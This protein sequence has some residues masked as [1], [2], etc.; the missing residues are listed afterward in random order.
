MRA[1]CDQD[2]D[3][4]PL[5]RARSGCPRLGI[6]K[7]DSAPG[8]RILPARRTRSNEHIIGGVSGHRNALAATLGRGNFD[9]GLGRRARGIAALY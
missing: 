2:D 7:G 4:S 6:P 1:G 9:V 3:S 5:R 8:R